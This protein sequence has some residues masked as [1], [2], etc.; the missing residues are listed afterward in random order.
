M[1][2]NFKPLNY[3][4][5]VNWLS[6]LARR[7]RGT[8]V[9]ISNI[10]HWR[11]HKKKLK[12]LLPEFFVEWSANA[13]HAEG[14][15]LQEGT[16]DNEAKEMSTLVRWP[17][18]SKAQNLHAKGSCGV[19]VWSLGGSYHATFPKSMTANNY[20]THP[21]Y[22]KTLKMG[23]PLS[24]RQLEAVHHHSGVTTVVFLTN[25]AVSIIMKKI[26]I[27]LPMA[28]TPKNSFL[29]TTNIKDE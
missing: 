8:S 29:R 28:G 3:H 4:L 5:H 14:D 11:V 6:A 24:M 19:M 21:W 20:N 15:C 10:G 1:E 22:W 23:F 17:R 9:K 18:S 26:E 27:F 2:I 13:K 12:A 7:W 25:A 16:E